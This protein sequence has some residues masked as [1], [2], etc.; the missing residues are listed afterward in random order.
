M[1]LDESL[2]E[3]YRRLELPVTASSADVKRAYRRLRARYHPD[4]HKGREASVEPAF[5]RIQEAFEILAGKRA[6]PPS[7]VSGSSEPSPPPAHARADAA[8]SPVHR[9]PPLRGANCAVELF[10]PLEAALH[11]GDVEAGYAVK[12]PC[13]AC[14]GRSACCAHCGGSGRLPSGMRCGACAG[15][16]RPVSRSGCA[17]CL[18]SGIAAARVTR[19]VA[20]AAGA[21]DGQRLVVEGAGHPGVNGGP[22]GDAIFTVAIVCGPGV[23]RDGL[24]LACELPVDFVTATLGG[25]Y[26]A[27]VLGGARRLSI[28]PN[29]QPGSTLRLIGDGLADRSGARGTLTL[30]LVLTMPAGAAHLN[31]DERH[32]L[33]EM[34]AQAQRR[35]ARADRDGAPR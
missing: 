18:G 3:Y 14:Q 17:D 21:W 28:A 9:G 24:N 19:T 5:K 1:S 22:A 29:A 35:A 27:H 7:T 13:R 30:H 23:R 8:A 34:F 20:V 6:A 26:D 2:A 11:G 33:R 16:G 15:T 31:A 10:V 25:P 32:R 12:G 4:R